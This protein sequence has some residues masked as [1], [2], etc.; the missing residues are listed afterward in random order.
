MWHVLIQTTDKFQ[1]L[2]TYKQYNQIQ[3]L[4]YCTLRLCV[5][6]SVSDFG[7]ILGNYTAKTKNYGMEIPVYFWYKSKGLKSTFWPSKIC[8]FCVK[9]FGVGF[10]VLFPSKVS[11]IFERFLTV[12]RP[13]RSKYQESWKAKIFDK[14]IALLFIKP[15]LFIKIFS[16]FSVIFGN[17]IL[18]AAWFTLLTL[19][20]SRLNW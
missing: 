17:N 8:Y 16:H 3:T 12:K 4:T 11:I 1:P 13:V 14:R 9:S 10:D 15:F 19:Q 5:P 20:S 7:I 2:I 18:F 6:V